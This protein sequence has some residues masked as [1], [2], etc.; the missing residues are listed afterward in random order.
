MHGAANVRLH[1]PPNIRLEDLLFTFAG[2]VE[3]Y[4]VDEDKLVAIFLMSQDPI[5]GYIVGASGQAR[6]CQPYVTR[7]SE[8][9]ND[10]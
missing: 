2:M 10:L 9:V 4:G 1:H 5:R 8:G 3:W 6:I 7:T